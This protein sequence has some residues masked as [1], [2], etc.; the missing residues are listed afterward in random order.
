MI[1]IV[2]AWRMLKKEEEAAD[3]AKSRVVSGCQTVDAGYRRVRRT[4]FFVRKTRYA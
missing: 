1:L 2:T 4:E 3:P